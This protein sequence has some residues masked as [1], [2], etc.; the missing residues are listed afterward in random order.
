MKTS[1]NNGINEIKITKLMNNGI[2]EIKITKLMNVVP[3]AFFSSL[4]RVRV[5]TTLYINKFA[6]SIVK[7]RNKLL[8]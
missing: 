4:K 5:D 8:K 7:I 3:D 1:I 2:N 6:I